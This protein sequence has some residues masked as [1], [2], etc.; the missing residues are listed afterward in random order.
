MSIT[1]RLAKSGG[2]LRQ[3]Y[4]FRYSIYVEEMKRSPR[5]ADHRART[6]EEPLDAT[7][8]N[9]IALDG[10]T[11]VGALRAN[12]G[13]ESDFGEYRELYEMD[14][15]GC[16]FPRHVSM[17]SK[18]MIARPYRGSVVAMRLA[19]ACFELGNLREIYFDF[20]D[21]NRHLEGTYSKVGYLPYRGRVWHPEYG[22]VLPM[23]LN[24]T[25]TGYLAAVRSPYLRVRRRH[26]WVGAP[27]DFPNSC[28]SSSI[29]GGT[30]SE[31]N[32][33][34]LQTSQPGF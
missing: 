22:D 15:A 31:L 25:D 28:V 3:L 7:G 20:M 10:D 19:L 16:W 1:I 34:V 12:L 14:R 13:G 2:E 26:P 17:T 23:V 11:I 18:F 27:V 30:E 24:L 5:Y 8:H 29:A 4:H 32:N 21:T 33:L 6:L 9:L